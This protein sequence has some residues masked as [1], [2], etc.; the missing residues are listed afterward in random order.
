VK[1]SDT[2][3]FDSGMLLLAPPR[4]RR[5]PAVHRRGAWSFPRYVDDPERPGWRKPEGPEIGLTRCRRLIYNSSLK[6]D[7]HVLHG[8]RWDV[9]QAIGAKPCRICFGS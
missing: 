1:P 5:L 7:Q 8:I 4:S 3:Y 6:H 2:V 9:A